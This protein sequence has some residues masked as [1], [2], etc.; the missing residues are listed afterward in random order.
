MA[1]SM[2]WRG[3][4][5]SVAGGLRQQQPQQQVGAR[6]CAST[7]ANVPLGPPDPIFGLTDAFNKVR[8]VSL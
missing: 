5:R 1:L 3:V 8:A 2:M 6:A 4:R 7:F